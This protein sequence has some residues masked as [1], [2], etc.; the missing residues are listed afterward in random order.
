MKVP[1]YF[2]NISFPVFLPPLPS[3]GLEYQP[4]SCNMTLR[5]ISLSEDL[6]VAGT[7]VPNDCHY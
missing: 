4:S 6:G 7:W 5:S 3:C 1:G 2:K